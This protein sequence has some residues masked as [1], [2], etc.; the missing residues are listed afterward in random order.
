MGKIDPIAIP[1]CAS[2]HKCATSKF[3]FG[4]RNRISVVFVGSTNLNLLGP[5]KCRRGAGLGL[6]LQ[7]P[8]RKS[9][10]TRK[11]KSRK[12]RT[13]KVKMGRMCTKLGKVVEAD[14]GS[15]ESGSLIVIE[16]TRWVKKDNKTA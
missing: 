9:S 15:G 3:K 1:T 12:S 8:S 6:K 5:G 2:A 16:M 11:W 10:N 14:S 13:S 7:T 4:R